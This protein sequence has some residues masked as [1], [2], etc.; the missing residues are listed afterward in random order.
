[1]LFS[2]TYI[3]T[4][5]VYVTD[6]NNCFEYYLLCCNNIE[7][8]TPGDLYVQNVSKSRQ[9]IAKLGNPFVTDGTV[10]KLASPYSDHMIICCHVDHPDAFKFQGC[11]TAS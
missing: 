8:L 5:T 1:M 7:Y 10:S 9:K 3:H 2:Y 6:D 4:Y 11:L